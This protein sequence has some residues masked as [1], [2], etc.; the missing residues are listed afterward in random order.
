M[1]QTQ[2]PIQTIDSTVRVSISEASRLFGVNPRTIR[3]A[4]AASELTY[5]VVRGR[6]KITFASLVQWS[7]LNAKRERKRDQKGIGQWVETWRIRNTL[8]S[9]RPPKNPSL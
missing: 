9:P 1:K 4:L 6:Y 5:I 3:R 8:Y 7:Q 2:G